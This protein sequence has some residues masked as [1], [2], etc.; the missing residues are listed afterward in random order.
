M[1]LLAS[2]GTSASVLGLSN[3]I[4]VWGLTLS[5]S[6]L[7]GLAR[8]QG[9]AAFS[10]LWLVSELGFGVGRGFVMFWRR[11]P[12]HC[13]LSGFGVVLG[14]VVWI[15]VS[16][17]HVVI[18]APRHWP[19]RCFLLGFGVISGVML[20]LRVRVRRCSW[21]RGLAL[22]RLWDRRQGKSLVGDRRRVIH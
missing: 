6:A 5:R 22:V 9:S 7:I 16:I 20:W 19:C 17:R 2:V 11:F 12:L 1:L 13:S 14:I 18:V 21:C 4:S 10:A 15:G 3:Q 8:C